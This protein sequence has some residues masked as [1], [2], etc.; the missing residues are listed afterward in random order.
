MKGTIN[1]NVLKEARNELGLSLEQVSKQLEISPSALSN[2][3]NDPKVLLH[4]S[5]V[6]L[7]KIASY[8]DLSINELANRIIKNNPDYDYS[9]R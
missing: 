9:Q 3:E 1:M 5:Y 4:I 7:A 6:K 2:Y 8:Y